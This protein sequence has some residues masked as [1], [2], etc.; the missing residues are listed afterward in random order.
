MQFAQIEIYEFQM[1]LTM[2]I[3]M[4]LN[5]NKKIYFLMKSEQKLIINVLII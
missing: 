2:T 5:K 3:V 1:F 4:T